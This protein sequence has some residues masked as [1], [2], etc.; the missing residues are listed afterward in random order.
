M[1][2]ATKRADRFFPKITNT[3]NESPVK[4]LFGN[5]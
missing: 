3:L 4:D 5:R 2:H 1:R